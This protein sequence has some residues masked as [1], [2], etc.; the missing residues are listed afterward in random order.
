MQI[1][2]P[3]QPTK[4]RVNHQTLHNEK[5]LLLR[6]ARG[7]EMAYRIIYDHYRKRIYAFAL[8]LTESETQADEIIQEVFMKVW[9]HR[10][11]LPAVTYFSTWLHTI[12]RN[13]IFDAL[14][15]MAR[16]ASV[17]SKFL[18]GTPV[19]GNSVEDRL[20]TKENEQ[21]LR[22]AI[23]KL[24]AQQ[25]L[26][27]HLS[28]HQGLKHDEIATRLNISPNTVKVHMVNALKTIRAHVRQHTGLELAIML[29]FGTGIGR[30]WY[31]IFL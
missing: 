12:A 22:E 26:I 27:Y 17:R 14:K 2:L 10:S 24:S 18:D 7:D 16:E 3:D 20:L 15:R 9:M 19:A 13:C 29:G 8:H 6:V 5:E 31:Q 21:I 28:R 25:Q 4:T 30:I 11:K 23:S 1:P